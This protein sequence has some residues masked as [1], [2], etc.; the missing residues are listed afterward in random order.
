LRDATD[1][2]EA[3]HMRLY[4]ASVRWQ[5]A[6]LEGAAEQHMGEQAETWM[7]SQKIV[8]PDRMAGLHVPGMPAQTKGE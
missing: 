7:R 2:C 6:R 4:S 1:R 8:R 5:L 3:T